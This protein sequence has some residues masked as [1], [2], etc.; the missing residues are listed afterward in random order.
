MVGVVQRFGKMV[1]LERPIHPKCEEEACDLVAHSSKEWRRSMWLCER[2]IQK[3][4]GEA[5]DLVNDSSKSVEE[6]QVTWRPFIQSVG[7]KH[8]TWRPFIQKYGGKSMWLGGHSSKVWRRSMWLGGP[9]IQSVEEK[10]VTWWPIHPKCGERSMW[11]GGYS[12]KSV[13]G[14]THDLG[15]QSVFGHK[16]WRAWNGERGETNDFGGNE[17]ANPNFYTSPFLH[18]SYITCFLRKQYH[19]GWPTTTC[20]WKEAMMLMV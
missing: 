13:R 19:K 7:K 3:C 14:G 4:G 18:N 6:K 5:S 12:S 20:L 8:M 15:I 16:R 1:A 2:F 9:F 11:L 17:Y 10:H